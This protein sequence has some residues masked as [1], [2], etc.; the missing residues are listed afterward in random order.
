MIR[1][2]ATGKIES[3]GQ[4]NQEGSE[5]SSEHYDRVNGSIKRAPVV[6]GCPFLAP[7]NQNK[8]KKKKKK[9]DFAAV[10]PKGSVGEPLVYLAYPR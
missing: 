1:A 10:A 6:N 3:V 7:I 4:R 2:K 9:T 8:K 5:W